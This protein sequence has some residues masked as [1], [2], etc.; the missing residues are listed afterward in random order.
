MKNI[1]LSSLCFTLVLTSCKFEPQTTGEE[2][3]ENPL[4]MNPV[5]IGT[6]TKKEGHVD[7]Q[8][9]GIYTIYQQ[10]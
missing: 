1:F 4:K 3:V 5:Y 10:L 9:V 2:V 6:Y 8:A 7:G